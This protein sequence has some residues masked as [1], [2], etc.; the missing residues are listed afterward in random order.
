[1]VSVIVPAYN[2]ELTLERCINA[3]LHQT[4]RE[5]EVLL[6]LDGST[7]GTLGIAQQLAKRD[8]RI[9]LVTSLR[10]RGVVRMRNIGTRL[11]KGSWIAFCDADDW[12]E[13]NKLEQQFKL[14]YESAANVLYSAFY[15][16][17]TNGNIHE[18]QLK[19]DATYKDMLK[20][21]AI[22]MS[23]SIYSVEQLGKH[24]F[25][26]QTEGIIHEDYAFW[27]RLFKTKSVVTS[28]L[29]TPTTFIELS[30]ESRSFNKLKAVYSHA[31]ILR[32]EAKIPYYR[33]IFNLWNYAIIALKKRIP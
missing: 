24:Y 12:W 16:V 21:N 19:S 10:N 27:L 33:M 15:F 7:D 31:S 3:V 4:Y 22:P 5:L 28:Y 30:N 2:A 8:R 23:T 6:L 14:A 26:Q 18:V 29:H 13:L 17:R 11:A 20:S 25:Q 1:M 32:N 9:R